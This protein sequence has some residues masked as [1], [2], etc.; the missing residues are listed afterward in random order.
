VAR[1]LSRT[2][3]RRIAFPALAML[4]HRPAARGPLASWF[5]SG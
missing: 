1:L 3:V 5:L 2:D 4:A